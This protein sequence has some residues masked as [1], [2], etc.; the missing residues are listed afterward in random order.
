[1]LTIPNA[2]TLVRFVCIP[3]FLW[4]VFGRESYESAAYLLAVL[5][6]TDWVDGYIARHFN[7]V[8]TVGKVFDPTVDRLML[9]TAAVTLI[10]VGALPL[11][12]GLI[13]LGRE[14]V[15]IIAGAIVYMRGAARIDVQFIGKAG[16]MFLMISMPLFLISIADIGWANIARVLAYC[17]GILGLIAS[18]YSVLGYKH[19]ADEAL[20]KGRKHD[21]QGATEL[22]RV[23]AKLEA[24]Q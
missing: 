12:F 4:L 24:E 10:V 7:Q 6:A 9:S 8:S 17:F 3:V 15:V 16:A 21:A 20:T 11:W 2:I 22:D 18:C 1:M 14:L 5:G 19:L 23:G 13:A